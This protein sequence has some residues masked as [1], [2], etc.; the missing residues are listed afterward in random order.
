MPVNLKKLKSIE[1][2][3]ALETLKKIWHASDQLDHQPLL[4]LGIGRTV[5][6][7]WICNMDAGTSDL[8]LV[9]SVPDA[10]GFPSDELVFLSVRNIDWVSVRDSKPLFSLLSGGAIDPLDDV[11][12]PG[13]L[14]L[15]RKS[16]EVTE[17][18][19]GLTGKQ[20]TIEHNWLESTDDSRALTSLGATLEVLEQALSQIVADDFAK[21]AVTE[22]IRSI[23]I[24]LA[25]QRSCA[26]TEGV[27]TITLCPAAAGIGRYNAKELKNEL[28]EL[29]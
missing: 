24:T 4:T 13:K 29:L 19:A 10:N 15:N 28:N 25:G 17:Q 20:I 5:L 9:L 11:P 8:P 12:A 21:S 22:K 23:A 16:K 6:T 14:Q 2:V 3:S 1:A 7:G 18:L 26:L 27:L